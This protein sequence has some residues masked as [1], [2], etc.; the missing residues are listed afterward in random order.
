MITPLDAEAVRILLSGESV[1]DW[2]RL[3]FNTDEEIEA[4]L[5]VHE[6]DPD[7]P[8]DYAHMLS[9]QRE[10]LNY[11]EDVLR[12]RMPEE[13]KNARDVRDLL[14]FA[15]QH[16]GIKRNRIYA[17]MTLKVMHIWHHLLA[18]ELLFNAPLSEA[19]LSEMLSKKIYDGIDKMR[20][21]GVP[22]VEYAGERKTRHSLVT[23]LLAKREWIA[24]QIVKRKR[25]R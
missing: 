7:N 11:L 9:L 18:R 15:S 17:C 24:A 14:R 19:Q 13:I 4:F 6:F 22:V 23:K 3:E 21:A 2:P 10:A 5:R 12:Y 25:F 16:Q 1:I 20:A 8:V